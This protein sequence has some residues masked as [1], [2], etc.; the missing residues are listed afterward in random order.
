MNQHHTSLFS[1]IILQVLLQCH[2]MSRQYARRRALTLSMVYEGMASILSR[3]EF[4]VFNVPHDCSVDTSKCY[5]SDTG[6]QVL[7]IR[8]LIKE[9]LNNQVF[10]ITVL[11]ENNPL[12]LNLNFGQ[13]I[14]DID[15][16]SRRGYINRTLGVITQH[17]NNTK[18][19][20]HAVLLIL[21]VIHCDMFCL[22][23]R[24]TIESN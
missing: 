19:L 3:H 10:F 16:S 21:S 1:H 20:F 6:V 14:W 8:R 2:Y 12:Y 4:G 17:K 18:H 5:I 15:V 9:E 11:Q 13:M 24:I 22:H 7:D 23:E